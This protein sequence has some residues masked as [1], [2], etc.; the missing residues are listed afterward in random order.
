[1][2]HS[3]LPSLISRHPRTPLDPRYRCHLD[4]HST[5]TPKRRSHRSSSPCPCSVDQSRVPRESNL[6]PLHRGS[7]SVLLRRFPLVRMERLPQL[8]QIK[9][10]SPTISPEI[11]T[12]ALAPSIIDASEARLTMGYYQ[13]VSLEVDCPKDAS[14]TEEP[15]CPGTMVWLY[16]ANINNKKS[17]LF[18]MNWWRWECILECK[19]L[20]KQLSPQN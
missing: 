17:L 13:W 4:C 19:V 12:G 10:A 9:T 2:R 3:N 18:D 16:D 7:L 8:C 1:M 5:L 20:L 14:F 15:K 11:P 6:L